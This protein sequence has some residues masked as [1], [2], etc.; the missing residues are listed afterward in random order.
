M[1]S[2]KI[3]A[4]ENTE[5]HA[6]ENAQAETKATIIPVV[7]EQLHVNTQEV[8][9]GKVHI[10]KTVNTEHVSVDV[11]VIREDVVVERKAINQYIDT[12]PPA[13]RQEGDV[14]IVSVV[15]EVLVKRLVLVEELHIT[16]HRTETT[17]TANETLRREEVTVN[18]VPNA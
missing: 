16:K 3:F 17:T 9:T 18:R 15:Q 2:W 5:N 1:E 6:E 4:G 10:A 13:I 14:T 12:A 8:E 11:P 7:Q